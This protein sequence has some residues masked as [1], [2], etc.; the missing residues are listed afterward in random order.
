MAE[1]D[2]LGVLLGDVC[3]NEI[4]KNTYHVVQ[5]LGL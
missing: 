3:D 1:K 2:C 4:A 5:S